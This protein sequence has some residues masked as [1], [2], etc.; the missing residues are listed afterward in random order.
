MSSSGRRNPRTVSLLVASL[1][2]LIAPLRACAAEEATPVRPEPAARAT[3]DNKEL[4][5]RLEALADG[6]RTSVDG[7]GGKAVR[8]AV[9]VVDAADGEELFA[10]DAG[11]PLVPA[12]NM[13]LATTA[14]ALAALGPDWRFHTLVG[15]VGKDLVV[16]GG[17]DPNLS[18]RFYDGDIV[19]AFRRWAAILRQRGITSVAG[20]LVFDDSLFEPARVHATWEQADLSR[21]SAAPI[22]ALVANDSCVD[23]F[24]RGA[25]KAGRPAS[26][27]IDPPTRYFAVGGAVETKSRSRNA[28]WATWQHEPRRLVFGGEVSPG[29]RPKV[30][31]RPVDDPGL[32]A[33][34]LIR[35]TLEGEGVA[36]EGGVVRR[37]V[38]TPEWRMPEEFRCQIIHTSSL[39][40]TIRV[41]NTRS[42]NLYAECL[43][44]TVAA[45]A[46]AGR[47]S[48]DLR[49]PNGEGSWAA[50]AAAVAAHLRKLGV[51]VRGCVFADGSG[52]SRDNR[53]TVR[54]LTDLLVRM[55]GRPGR[56]VW[57]DSLARWGDQ[58][59]TLRI[60]GDDPALDGRVSAKTGYLR[61]TRA[62]S[63]YVRT[64]SGRTLA[65]AMLADGL[66]FRSTV[67]RA[68]KA[69][70][71]ETLRL[72]AQH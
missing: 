72:L 25:G 61:D 29:S 1:A 9:R 34:T 28:F 10:L 15:L 33:A 69:W 18:G 64:D 39:A 49:W 13:K 60:Y 5:A 6:L 37:R 40:Q 44:K 14:A 47:E 68:V 62:L 23:V 27:R 11:V 12:S 66:P 46:G 26:I 24:V 65:F 45:Y 42:Q 53:L 50:G 63:G 48:D 20:N 58:G 56:E 59:G 43:M 35:E 8:F 36:V 54:A 67:H 19:G 38:W 7:N 52:L 51:D 16:V 57:L 2:A 4:A 55:A 71:Y 3:I 22:G 31:W 21:Y 32:F 70:H 41:A 17:G 30:Y